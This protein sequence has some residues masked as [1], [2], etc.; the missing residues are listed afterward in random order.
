[1][2]VQDRWDTLSRRHVAGSVHEHAHGRGTVGAG[3]PP[4]LARRRRACWSV[5]RRHCIGVASDLRQ[6]IEAEVEPRKRV[7]KG[8]EL[9][10]DEVKSLHVEFISDDHRSRTVARGPLKPDKIVRNR[11]DPWTCRSSCRPS[12]PPMLV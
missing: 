7:D 1:M 11:R 4:F 5:Q 2:Q 9:G 12:A 6:V 10:I 3:D 8:D